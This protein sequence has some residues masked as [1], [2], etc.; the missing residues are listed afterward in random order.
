MKKAVK[1]I[2]ILL[3]FISIDLS[4]VSAD[5]VDYEEFN[6]GEIEEQIT[7]AS[8]NLSNFPTINSR[9]FV[10]FDRVSKQVLYGKNENVKGAMASTTKIMTCIVVLENEN[11][12]KEV[13]VSAKAAGTGGSRLG[14]KKNDKITV[15]D[16][17]YGLMLKS[18]NDAAIALAEDVSESVENFS[19]LMN[20][21]AKELNLNSTHFVT[22]HGLDNSEHYTTAVE[23]AKI[24]DYAMQNE[25]FAKIVGTKMTTIK[26]NNSEK[27]I[28]NTNE[29]LGNL[30]GVIG[31]KTGFTNNAGRC[32][33][34]ETKR[35]DMD[36]IA[37]VL[38]ADTKKYR[39][40][41]S[42]NLI[43]YTYSNYDLVDLN[44]KILEEFE[45]W[46]NIN[47]KR[48]QVIKGK[49]ENVNIRLGEPQI[50]KMAVKRDDIDK[51]KIEINC[52][53]TFEAPVSPNLRMGTLN[54][55]INEKLIESL[56]IFTAEQ[57]ERKQW[58]DYFLD[59][60]KNFML[61]NEQTLT[62]NINNVKILS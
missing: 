35:G 32:L 53:T 5:I 51:I 52:I 22:P 14:L 39:T 6:Q 54:V 13:T 58:N 8:N 24:A 45:K 62:Q 41:D 49:K 57:V 27:V 3:I 4:T 23:L 37:V 12:D 36:I 26:I 38:G 9:R 1:I 18:G 40:K 25:T 43:E 10:V 50:T 48:I 11:L 2:F 56:E 59:L 44:S 20:E 47:L 29:L 34:T 16:L 31:I 21:K 46:K 17:L 42:V 33:V 28:S 15:K 55:Y 61:Y 60:I 30:N 7:E 19:E